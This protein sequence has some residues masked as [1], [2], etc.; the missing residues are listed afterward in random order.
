MGHYIPLTWLGFSANYRGGR[1]ESRG[2]ITW[3]TSC[4]TPPTRSRSTSS[5]AAS[6]RRPR[7][8]GR[9]DRRAG[10]GPRRGAP[11]SRLSSSPSIRSAS[12]PSPGSPS[13]A[14]FRVASSISPRS[15]PICGRGGRRPGPVALARR[16]PAPVRGRAAIEGLDHGVARRPRAA[17]R[18]PATAWCVASVVAS[19][20]RREGGLLGAGSRRR[21]RRADRLAIVGP[22]DHQLRGLRT[23]RPSRHDGLQLLVLPGRLGMARP[24]LAHV[25]AAGSRRSAG[26]PFSGPSWASSRSPFFWSCSGDGGRRDCAAWIYSALLILPISGAVHAG[27]QLA[28]D[29]YSYLSGLG[30]ALVAGGAITWALAAL[31]ARKMSRPGAG[32]ALGVAALVIVALASRAGSSCGSGG[33]RRRSGAGASKRTPDARSVPTTL[34]P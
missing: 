30:F 10:S 2:A 7:D 29:R 13:G 6:S 11:P 18:L 27:F 3:S 17:R 15:S 26:R 31:G 21:R 22:A 20:R 5:R 1:D 25:R 4:S 33:T 12:S 19:A 28:H 24:A 8:G 23:G 9:Q 14:T 16:V 34:R 32:A